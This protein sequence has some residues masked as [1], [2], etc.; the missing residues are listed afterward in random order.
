MPG[1]A[2]TAVRGSPTSDPTSASRQSPLMSEGPPA[3]NHVPADL[4]VARLR[5]RIKELEAEIEDRD[6]KIYRLGRQARKAQNYLL[7]PRKSESVGMRENVG[8]ALRQVLIGVGID[9]DAED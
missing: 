5:N 4:D 1:P 9:P 7:K 2:R 3:A 8:R 6:Q